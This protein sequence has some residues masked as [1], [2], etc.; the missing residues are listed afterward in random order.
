[1][2][3]CRVVEVNLEAANKDELVKFYEDAFGMRFDRDQHGSGPV[4][5]H[6]VFGTWQTDSFFLLNISQADGEPRPSSFGF[7]VD[8][9][10]GSHRRGIAAG[11]RE[12]AAPQDIPGM[13]RSSSLEDPSG[14]TVNLYQA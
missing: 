3:G 8:D 4:H 10:K 13:P 9:L 14:N 6:V 2:K 5:Y 1:V 7:L 12:V 11:A